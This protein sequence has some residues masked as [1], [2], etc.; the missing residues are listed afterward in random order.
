MSGQYKD[1]RF[2]LFYADDITFKKMLRSQGWSGAKE[3]FEFKV[4][5]DMAIYKHKEDW[6]LPYN[7]FTRRPASPTEHVINHMNENGELDPNHGLVNTNK[8]TKFEQFDMSPETQNKL[9][10]LLGLKNFRI[11]IPK[12]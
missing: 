9:I 6:M 4:A 12:I 10:E 3:Y 11:L 8:E 5:Q 1:Y 2:K 7:D